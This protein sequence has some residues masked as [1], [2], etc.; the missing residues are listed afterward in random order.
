MMTELYVRPE[1]R[2]HLE[3]FNEE[4][5]NDVIKSLGD[6]E[7]VTAARQILGEMQQSRLHKKRT[8]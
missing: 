7:V 6:V 4:Q 5:L 3:K 2:S 1:L 8:K